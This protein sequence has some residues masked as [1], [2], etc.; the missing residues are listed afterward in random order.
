MP[1][2]LPPAPW[3]DRLD[4][5]RLADIIGA[6]Q[7]ESRYVGGAVR[8]TLLGIHVADIDIATRLLPDAVM[9]RLKRAGIRVVPTGIAHGTVTAVLDSG[10]IE[11]TTLRRDVSTDGRH[12]TI[13]FST[14]WQEDAARRDFTINALYADPV[15]GAIHDYFGGL[16]DLAARR[17]RFIGNALTRIAEDHLR[18]LRFF[19]FLARFGDTPD[20]EGLAACIERAN[21]LMALS[22]ERVAA[23]LLKLLVAPRAAETVALMHANGIF[24][25]VLPEIEPTGVEALA[26]LIATEAAAGLAPDPVRRLTALLPGDPRVVEGVAA[27]LRLSN[28]QRKRMASATG[29]LDD[30]PQPLAWRLGGETATD[31]L[32]MAGDADSARSISGWTP[33]VLPVSGGTLIDMGLTR[34]P[35]VAAALRRVERRWLDEGFPDA[36]RATS[37]AREVVDQLLRERRNASA[38]DGGNG[39]E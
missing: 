36:G 6:G 20:P 28:A 30:A 26:R 4:L 39:R 13:A 19:R 22:R 23:E 29:P 8:D 9:A 24:T 18:I 5:A 37:I 35:D 32:L 10:P 1:T 27:R 17:V 14:D 33:P 38:S 2:H 3:R 7:G 16:D 11:I 34:G 12:A 31:R 21:D 25:P 15:T